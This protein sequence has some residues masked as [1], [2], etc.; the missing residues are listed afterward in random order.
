VADANAAPQSIVV[1]DASSLG[2]L[3]ERKHVYSDPRAKWQK[4]GALS[5]AGTERV[6]SAANAVR[7]P[8][9]S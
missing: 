6:G 1:A 2:E 4:Y 8:T 9:K 7:L 5:E 3:K